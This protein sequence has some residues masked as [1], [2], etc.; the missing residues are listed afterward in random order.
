MNNDISSQNGQENLP[1]G[2]P[3]ADEGMWEDR[4]PQKESPKRGFWGTVR[5]YVSDWEWWGGV[6]LTIATA[7]FVVFVLNLSERVGKVERTLSSALV[8]SSPSYPAETTDEAIQL[9]LKAHESGGKALARL[10]GKL[11]KMGEKGNASAWNLLGQY[12]ALGLGGETNGFRAGQCYRRAAESGDGW[13][14]YNLACYHWFGDFVD[15]NGKSLPRNIYAAISAMEEAKDVANRSHNGYLQ[16]KASFKLASWVG[17]HSDPEEDYGVTDLQA[18]AKHITEATADILRERGCRRIIGNDYDALLDL[19]VILLLNDK[20]FREDFEKADADMDNG[21]TPSQFGKTLLAAIIESRAIKDSVIWRLLCG[22]GHGEDFLAR[23][24]PPDMPA[25]SENSLTMR[26]FLGWILDRGLANV[27]KSPEVWLVLGF[28]PER[29][30]AGYQTAWEKGDTWVAEMLPGLFEGPVWPADPVQKISWLKKALPYLDQCQIKGSPRQKTL[31][32]GGAYYRLGCLYG[33]GQG[34][35]A[36][37]EREALKCF[38]HT[39]YSYSSCCPDATLANNGLFWRFLHGWPTSPYDDASFMDGFFVKCASNPPVL[40]IDY[41]MM[42]EP[43]LL[44]IYELRTNNLFVAREWLKVAS[45]NG[46]DVAGSIMERWD[47]IA[48]SES[49]KTP[50]VEGARHLLGLSDDPDW[51]EA[52]AVFRKGAETGDKECQHALVEVLDAEWWPGSDSE[53]ARRQ[54]LE[55]AKGG[56]LWAAEYFLQVYDKTVVGNRALWE[57]NAKPLFNRF[58]N[59]DSETIR[60]CKSFSDCVDRYWPLLQEKLD[61]PVSTESMRSFSELMDE[62]SE[63]IDKLT[64]S[65]SESSD[66]EGKM[67]EENSE[68]A[69]PPATPLPVSSEGAGN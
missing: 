31:D 30:R 67:S 21:E 7:L 51:F 47:V 36:P 3:E 12:W 15:E 24:V 10:P 25:S 57:N 39:I 45:S 42:W 55:F 23:F 37:N 59:A 65:A 68:T 64:I 54:A 2:S 41:P 35:I 18:A 22:L 34:L 38:W 61:S 66:G 52:V 20:D 6:L 46:L 60:L 50:F 32:I 16:K 27:G 4:E 14:S 1:N 29:I 19:A 33:T 49:Q 63:T 62:F 40:K 69:S 28:E 44:G 56:D 48:D 5:D 11:A 13:G 58:A 9:F 17:F 53:E 43:F 26:E 8:E